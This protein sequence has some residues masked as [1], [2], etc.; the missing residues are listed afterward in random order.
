QSSDAPGATTAAKAPVPTVSDVGTARRWLRQLHRLLRHDDAQILGLPYGDV[1]ADSAAQLDQPLLD[2]AIERTGNSL[3]PWGLP[4]SRVVAPPD[5]RMSGS[6]VPLLPR[7]TQVLL[8][9]DAV[10]GSTTATNAVGDRQVVLSSSGATQGGPGPVDPMSPLAL[11][12]R[13]L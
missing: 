11:R 6:V 7:S 3:A 1:A 4:L 8:P 10:V 13:I 12:Q 9:D 2:A 5:G